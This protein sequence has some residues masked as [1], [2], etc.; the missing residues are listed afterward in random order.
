MPAI[1]SAKLAFPEQCL[2][3]CN[4]TDGCKWWTHYEELDKTV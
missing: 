1:G 4:A 3:L 2:E